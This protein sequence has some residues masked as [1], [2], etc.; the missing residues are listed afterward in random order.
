MKQSWHPVAQTG[1][2]MYGTLAKLEK[3]SLGRMQKMDL[4]N[5][6]YVQYVYEIQ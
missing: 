5:S 3:S 1:V 4:Q 2:C 6:W